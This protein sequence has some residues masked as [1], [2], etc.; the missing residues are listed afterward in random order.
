MLQRFGEELIE[1]VNH[2]EAEGVAHRDIKPEN[3]GIAENRT[4]KLQLVLFDFSL[5]RTPADNITAGTHPYLDPF[6]SLRRPPRWDLYAERFALA[7]T[8]YEMAVGQPRS[9]ATANLAGHARRRGHHRERCLRPGHARRF[10]TFFAKALKRDYRERFDNAE[11]MLRAWRA[12]FAIGRRFIHETGAAG[13][14]GRHR[15]DRHAAHH[16]GRAGLQPGAQDILERMGIHNARELLAVDRIRFR[17]LRGVGDKIRKEIRLT[18]KE[19]AACGPTSRRAAAPCTTRTRKGGAVSVNEL[20]AQLLPRRPAGDDRPEEAALAHYLGLD[21]SVQAG[22]WPNLGESGT[23]QSGRPGHADRR[24]HQGP[25][26]LAQEPAFTELRQQLDT[27]LRSQG[28]VMSAHEAPW[29]APLRGCAA[30]DDAERL[31][32]ATRRAAGPRSKRS[33]TSTSRDSRRSTIQPCALIA[34]ASAWADYARQ[35]GAAADACAWPTPA[36]ATRVLE[37]LEGVPLPPPWPLKARPLQRP[38]TPPGCCVWPPRRR[39]KVAL[40]SRQ[41]IYP[42]HGAAAGPAPVPGRTGRRTCNLAPVREDPGTACA[43]ATPRLQALPGRPELDRL[44]EEAGAPPSWGPVRRGRRRR[45][46]VAHLGGAQ[47][48]GTT[49][50]F[51]RH[52]T[53]LTLR[54]AA[55]ARRQSRRRRRGRGTPHPRLAARRPSGADRSPAH[56]APGRS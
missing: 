17:Y 39:A 7:V 25:R 11:D 36:P 42:R 33:R 37:T 51:S 40:S 15:H 3:I 12:I 4:G 38:L 54:A 41:E 31:R 24:A 29:P 50:V 47:T 22:T 13:G 9:G 53:E 16:D 48:A 52:T 18:A 21:D 46:P 30:Q 1:A 5:C 26:T 19:L 20:A 55:T 6:L 28:Q 14:P 32:Q 43:V 23:S 56:C 34:S 35:L 8:L 44:L 10:T 2:L 49:T 45:V 27:L